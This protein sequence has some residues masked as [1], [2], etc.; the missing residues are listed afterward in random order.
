MAVRETSSHAVGV[1]LALA[2]GIG[3]VAFSVRTDERQHDADGIQVFIDGFI[4]GWN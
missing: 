4:I 1:V 2:L 3:T